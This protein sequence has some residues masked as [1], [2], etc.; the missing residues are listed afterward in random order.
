MG[1]LGGGLL[2][3][4]QAGVLSDIVTSLEDAPHGVPLSLPKLTPIHV[5]SRRGSV[6]G[7]AC[8]P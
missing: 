3:R 5:G 8:C 7:R 1:L 4:V 6:W 2:S